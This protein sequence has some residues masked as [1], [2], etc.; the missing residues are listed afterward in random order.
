MGGSSTTLA[1]PS[2]NLLPGALL[3]PPAQA[4]TLTGSMDSV[5][6]PAHPTPHQR[7]P[8]PRL[9]QQP[10]PRQ[11][12]PQPQFP[13]L[14]QLQPRRPPAAPRAPSPRSTATPASATPSGSTFAAPSPARE[15]PA[16]PRRQQ[17]QP[18]PPPQRLLQHAQSPLDLQPDRIVCS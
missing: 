1:P 13:L 8:P 2:A 17:P 6:P 7:P 10:R 18:P 11:Q 9:Q 12:Q 3:P 14:P 16:Q 15:L 4:P 5:R